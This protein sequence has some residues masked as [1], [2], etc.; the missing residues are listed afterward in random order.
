MM[1]KSV[2]SLKVL[3]PDWHIRHVF[4]SIIC[5]KQNYLKLSFFNM[6]LSGPVSL[7]INCITYDQ[8]NKFI[9]A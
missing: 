6:A 2:R 5:P 9:N 1:L 7:K 3:S 4:G 8:I